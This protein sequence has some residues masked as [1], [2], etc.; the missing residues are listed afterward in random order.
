MA[1][2]VVHAEPTSIH[3]LLRSFRRNQADELCPEL[4]AEDAL[5]H[6]SRLPLT[7]GG[8]RAASA[9]VRVGGLGA[10]NALLGA[11]VYLETVA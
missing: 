7:A 10:G 6:W 9:S 3:A 11:D 5:L 4:H 8:E 1:A 2:E